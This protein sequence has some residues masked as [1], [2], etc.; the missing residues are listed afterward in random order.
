V[1]LVALLPL[2]VI[3]LPAYLGR[4]IPLWALTVD[5]LAVSGPLAVL[6]GA[7]ALRLPMEVVGA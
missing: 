1:L 4:T 3:A 2:I 6:L 7:A 5:V